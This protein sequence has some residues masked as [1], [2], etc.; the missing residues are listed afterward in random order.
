MKEICWLRRELDYD[1]ASVAWLASDVHEELS[2]HRRHQLADICQGENRNLVSRHLEEAFATLCLLLKKVGRA[3]DRQPSSDRLSAR[4]RFRFLVTAEEADTGLIVE[5]GHRFL[6]SWVLS[7][8]LAPWAAEEAKIWKESLESLRQELSTLA[9]KSNGP[10]HY[11][12][13]LHPF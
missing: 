5:K 8:W 13:K 12:R 6:I 10:T 11:R 9:A 3:K 7:V 2:L 4:R 1:I